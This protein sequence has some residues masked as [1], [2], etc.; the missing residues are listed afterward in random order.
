MDKNEALFKYALRLGDNG[1]I[2]GH[3][4]SEWCSKGPF[5]EEDLALSNMALDLI[6][7]SQAMLNYAATV[8]GKGRTD[9]DLAFK[10]A[11]RQFLN[12]LLHEQP[13]GDFAHTMIRQLFNSAFELFFFEELAK[14][15]D[16]TFAGVAAKTVKEVKY[17]LR[18]ASEWIPRLGEGTEESHARTQKAIDN[19]WTYTGELFEMDEVDQVLIKEGIAVDMS[20]LKSKW[21]KQVRSVIEGATLK[22]PAGGFMQTGSRKGLHSEHLG[23]LLAEMQYLPRAYPDAKW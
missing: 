23:F 15:K 2:L 11:E 6:G 7:R 10:R 22:L 16:E 5:L 8:E 18:H 3:R 14:S 12:N 17:H 19:L 1:L 20:A 13:N 9:D 4:L 21:E